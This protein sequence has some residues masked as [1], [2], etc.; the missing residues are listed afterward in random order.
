MLGGKK[1][2]KDCQNWRHSRTLRDARHEWAIHTKKRSLAI[3]YKK[4]RELL[5]LFRS[6]I[7]GLLVDLHLLFG[8]HIPS[9]I[10]KYAYL[11]DIE[12]VKEEGS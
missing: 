12:L 1:L 2:K 11:G 9:I 8:E 6:G 4:L 7:A 3:S 5:N 10:V